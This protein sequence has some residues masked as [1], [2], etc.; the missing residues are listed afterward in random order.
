M[1]LSKI[2]SILPVSYV[3]VA[4]AGKARLDPDEGAF[5]RWFLSRILRLLLLPELL[6]AAAMPQKS[7]MRM[8]KMPLI[9]KYC[10]LVFTTLQLY[11]ELVTRMY[12]GV[13]IHRVLMDVFYECLSKT[14]LCNEGSII[15]VRLRVQPSTKGMTI[16]I[17]CR[18]PDF[19]ILPSPAID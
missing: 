17:N 7:R 1:F 12:Y 10:R 19:P 3:L 13:N 16:I 8:V 4:S 11:T 14:S 18:N 9:A 6:V 2:V 15:V 5:S